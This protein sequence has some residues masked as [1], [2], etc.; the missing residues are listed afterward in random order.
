MIATMSTPNIDNDSSRITKNYMPE[1][2]IFVRAYHILGKLSK[3]ALR[4]SFLPHWSDNNRPSR[5][6]CEIL[7]L[8]VSSKRSF[9]NVGS[10]WLCKRGKRR[11]SLERTGR[12]AFSASRVSLKEESALTRSSVDRGKRI[13]R[14]ILVPCVLLSFT[15]I[16]RPLLFFSFL[17]SDPLLLTSPSVHAVRRIYTT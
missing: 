2:L 1:R 4:T 14:E 17:F 5:R 15:W 3:K 16:R 10:C 11:S 7:W 13:P 12:D 9:Q 6:R 8:R